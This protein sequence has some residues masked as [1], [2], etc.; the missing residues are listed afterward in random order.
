MLKEL[1]NIRND[2][3]ERP[4]RESSSDSDLPSSRSPTKW[5]R[6][7]G[8]P[9]EP[10]SPISEHN[11]CQGNFERAALICIMCPTTYQDQLLSNFIES[12][13]S[14]E[15]MPTFRCHSIWLG[16]MAQRSKRSS[17]LVWAIR[18][19]SIAHLGRKACDEALTQTSRRVYG[20]A[21]VK[22]NGALQDR[23]EG[24]SSDTL[25][26]TVL[27][28]FYEILNCTGMCHH[29]LDDVNGLARDAPRDTFPLSI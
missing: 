22:L 1:Y 18:A 25:S 17:A 3:A 7:N 21:L 29:L 11:W 2:D 19:I 28:S 5:N 23:D 4:Y 16:Q 24:L 13:R 14:P 20:K 12:L 9:D 26:A 6:Q 10:L 15:V 27:L 8:A